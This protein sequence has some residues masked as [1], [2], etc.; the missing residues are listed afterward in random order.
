MGIVRPCLP[1]RIV[2][3]THLLVTYAAA[4]EGEEGE[5]EEEESRR[6]RR[7]DILNVT[8][9]MCQEKLQESTKASSTSRLIQNVVG[10]KDE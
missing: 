2:T 1:V 6:R 3:P 4:E 8:K 10:L 7:K 5:E 9:T